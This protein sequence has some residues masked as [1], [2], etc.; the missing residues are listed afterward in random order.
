MESQSFETGV[1]DQHHLIYTMLHTT[2]VKLPLK[3]V[4]YRD[5]KKFAEEEF[6]KDVEVGVRQI[7]PTKYFAL[8]AVLTS[9]LTKHCPLKQRILRGNNTQHCISRG[10][11]FAY[12]L[13]LI[14]N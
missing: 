11:P 1:H 8:Q 2:F 7:I 9:L 10:G 4:N 14:V 6:L 12:L 5:Y 3:I 13:Q